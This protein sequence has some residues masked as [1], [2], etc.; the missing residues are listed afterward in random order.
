MSLRVVGCRALVVPGSHTMDIKQSSSSRSF[1]APQ[2]DRGPE[3]HG[4][5]LERASAWP[6]CSPSSRAGRLAKLANQALQ[7]RLWELFRL[8]QEGHLVVEIIIGAC[9]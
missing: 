1:A 6:A 9:S 7:V 2:R 8:L 4:V 3:I 5:P